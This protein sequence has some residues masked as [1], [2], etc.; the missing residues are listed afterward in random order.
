MKIRLLPF[1]IIA[2]LAALITPDAIAQT[3]LGGG[4]QTSVPTGSFS[5]IFDGTP[6]GLGAS[7][8][9]PIFRR[10]PIHMGFGFGWNR[11]G[12]TDRDV[13]VPDMQDD[14]AS[15]NVNVITNR[16]TYDLLMRL[17]PLR[18]PF[19]P[20]FE[21]VAGWSNYIT[22]NELNTTYSSGETGEWTERLHNNMNWNYG[23]G[24]GFHLKLAP[25]IFLEAKVQRLYAS[26][27]SFVNQETM[28]INDDSSLE[29]D[30]IEGRPEFVTIHA[31]IT[32]KF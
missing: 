19:Q 14:L 10:A 11:I 24:A 2:V 22:K 20:F 31:G 16:Y 29:Y 26:E 3:S 6:V 8:T 27:T 32:F 21:G 4:V 5:N 23:W 12:H 28:T 15:G 13:Y 9:T 1:A 17:S 7:F 30:M 25:L 18:G